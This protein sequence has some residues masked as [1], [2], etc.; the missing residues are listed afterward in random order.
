MLACSGWEVEQWQKGDWVAVKR[1]VVSMVDVVA[2]SIRRL[3][4]PEYSRTGA[5]HSQVRAA[6]FVSD[7]IMVSVIGHKWAD[8]L[9]GGAQ[10][11]APSG[12]R[13]RGRR[14]HSSLCKNEAR[15][16]FVWVWS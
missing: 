16:L 8:E 15:D 9:R 2:A 3:P 12:F 5:S 7:F 13:G 14:I 11:K 6:R 10:L 1:S 4:M